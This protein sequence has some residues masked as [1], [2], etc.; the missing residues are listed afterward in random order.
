MY[1]LDQPFS[2]LTEMYDARAVSIL[3]GEGLLG[4]RS[5][6]P[7]DT[8]WLAQAPGYSIYL[9]AVYAVLSRNF[10]Q[11]Q[12]VQNAVNSL[13]A[14][15]I[16]L[17]GGT[18]VS[19]RVGVVA[20]FIA[21]VS[22]HLSYISNFILPDSVCA[23][24]LLGAVYLIAVMWRSGRSSYWPYAL[25]GA[26]LGIAAWLRPQ[27]ML[28][29]PFLAVM[30]AIITKKRRDVIGP[31]GVMALMSFVVIAPITINNWRVYGALLPINIGV[32]HNLWAGIG[33]A[34]GD[35]F[36]AVATDDG[37][38]Q[39][40]AILYGKPR[41]AGS[42]YSPDGISRDRDR[43]KK[44][45]RIIAEHPFWYAGVMLDR[46]RDMLKYS[47]YAQLVQRIPNAHERTEPVRPQW[48]DIASAPSALAFA[49]RIWWLRRPVRALQR[50][51]K[52]TMLLFVLIGAAL[53]S[54]ATWRRS[55]FLVLVPLYYLLFQSFLHTEFRYT[56]P[57]HYFLFIFAAMVWV[58]LGAM[59][60]KVLG[61]IF[62]RLS[63]H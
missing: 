14:V 45:L 1:T 19:W 62:P 28:L 58:L 39:Q 9:S 8:I 59:L 33:D 2:G 30:L 16:F 17:I 18:I 61:R 54:A 36:G 44:S 57:M 43:T 4:P 31:A 53:L 23:L 37:V 29:G 15:L 13:S 50:G 7:W 52:E 27:S 41:Y 56:L 25:A 47:A 51:V 34:S 48:E 40:E 42:P 26:L 32:G 5:V 35:R 11:V 22:H 24:P 12:L 3:N 49:D 60:A 55:L 21:A 63:H 46:M 6:R 10:F 20:G 38:A